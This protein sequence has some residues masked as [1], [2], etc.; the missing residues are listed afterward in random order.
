MLNKGQ[1]FANLSIHPLQRDETLTA[2]KR[3]GVSRVS[4]Q[5]V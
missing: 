1:I 3:G 2:G 5:R 4:E